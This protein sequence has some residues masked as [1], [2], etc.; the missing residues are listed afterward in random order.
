[1]SLSLNAYGQKD[2]KPKIN[3]DDKKERQEILS[4]LVLDARK[5]LSQVDI[6]PE[7][8]DTDTEMKNTARLLAKIL[9]QDIEED[10]SRKRKQ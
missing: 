1:M 8:E 3:W 10:K 9:S 2:P 7:N 4:L 5:V 6:G